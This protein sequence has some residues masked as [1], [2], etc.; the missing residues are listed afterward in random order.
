MTAAQGEQDPADRPKPRKSLLN[1]EALAGTLSALFT[2]TLLA[3]KGSKVTDVQAAQGECESKDP[4]HCRVHGTPRPKEKKPKEPRGVHLPKET[5]RPQ[6]APQTRQL[7]P[8]VGKTGS[9]QSLGLESAALFPARKGHLLTE[10]GIARAYR[11]INRGFTLR[12]AVIPGDKVRIKDTILKHWRNK[13]KPKAE[14]TR[15]MEV[16][17]EALRAF[18]NPQEVWTQKD[19][20]RA[21]YRSFKIGHRMEFI[22]G[23]VVN[24]NNIVVSFVRSNRIN[25]INNKRKGKLIY[26]AGPR[27]HSRATPL[28]GR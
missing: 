14:K 5:P 13:G 26:K 19:G 10:H 8:A 11:M 12:S 17:M 28:Y 3:K 18:K 27:G 6:D 2:Q 16:F 7:H 23:V 22:S 25:Y 1:R 9:W 20:M 4:E 24:K 15:R 21:Y